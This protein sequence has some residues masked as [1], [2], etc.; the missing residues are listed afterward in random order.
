MSNYYY[1]RIGVCNNRDLGINYPGTHY[2][3]IKRNIN[4]SKYD[5]HTITS[6]ENNVLDNKH[7]IPV[8]INDRG[9][10]RF[11]DPNKI[12]AMRNGNLYVIPY[13]DSNFPKW[14][15][16]THQPISVPKN[17]VRLTNKYIRRRHKFY[18]GKIY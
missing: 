8:R 11:I 14:S 7:T 3:Y 10:I 13:Y 6:I 18:V 1:G 16:I 17:K 9:D 12:K 5:V 4:R 2:V 15:G